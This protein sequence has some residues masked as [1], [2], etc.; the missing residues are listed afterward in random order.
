MAEYHC[1]SEIVLKTFFP[2]AMKVRLFFIIG[3]KLTSETFG[4]FHKVV[5]CKVEIIS[6]L[7]SLNL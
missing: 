3:E 1:I 5:T 7:D 6:F 4:N 2:E